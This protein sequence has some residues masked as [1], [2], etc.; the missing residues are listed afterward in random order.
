ML[1]KDYFSMQIRITRRLDQEKGFEKVLWF[2]CC[3]FL[4]SDMILAISGEENCGVSAG[5]WFACFQ[6]N[7]SILTSM[8]RRFEAKQVQVLLQY[9]VSASF[10]TK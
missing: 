1:I 3:S 10:Q 2:P 4:C 6:E 9:K 8:L 5:C 7:M